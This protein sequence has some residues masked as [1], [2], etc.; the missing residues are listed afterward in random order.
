[1][2]HKIKQIT[3]TDGKQ[4]FY[5]S[6]EEIKKLQKDIKNMI[7]ETIMTIEEFEVMYCCMECF[8]L[9]YKNNLK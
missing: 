7:T 8:A 1:M 3:L 5:P 6:E 2:K 4:L 9:Q